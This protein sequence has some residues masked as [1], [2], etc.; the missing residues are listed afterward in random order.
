[1]LYSGSGANTNREGGSRGGRGVGGGLLLLPFKINMGVQL[2]WGILRGGRSDSS[3]KKIF[4]KT[5][6]PNTAHKFTA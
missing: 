2:W 4:L 6:S 5:C 3:T 1:M